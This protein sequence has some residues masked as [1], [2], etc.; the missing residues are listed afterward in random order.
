MCAAATLSQSAFFDHDKCYFFQGEDGR[1]IFAIPYEEDF[2]LIGTTDAEH[3]DAN[4][5]PECTPEEADYLCA[6][7]SKYFET[8]VTQEDVV[9]TYSGVRPLYDDGASSATA[10]TRD[11]VLRVDKSAGGPILNVFGGKITT[12]RKLAESALE[13][14]DTALNRTTNPWTAHA[15]LP[16]GDI[17]Y[18]QLEESRSEMAVA[19][20]FFD[21]YTHRRL[22]RQYG[23]EVRE[24]F[25]NASSLAECGTDFGHGVT[26]R[27][28][29]WAIANEWVHTAEDFLWRRS[30]LGLRFTD[31][32]TARLAAYID[33]AVAALPEAS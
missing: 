2:T 3:G 13:E 29:D 16:G 20:P 33:Q 23:T 1:I 26:A 8:P 5:K 11:Y 32:E 24:V 9:W 18:A 4:T 6:F 27:E 10:A 25:D 17:S 14:I 31:D 19:L 12:Y 21:A 28:V 15:S 22:F 7:A 30:K